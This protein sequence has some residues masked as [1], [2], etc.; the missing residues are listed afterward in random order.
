MMFFVYLIGFIVVGIT[1]YKQVQWELKHKNE[2][3]REEIRNALYEDH[4]QLLFSNKID[5]NP[6]NQKM[7]EEDFN[8]I[9]NLNS[10]YYDQ[11]S[12]H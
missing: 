4:Q 6:L 1:F 5:K 11:K 10:N 12:Y 7:L 2:I 3:K 9:M 8:K